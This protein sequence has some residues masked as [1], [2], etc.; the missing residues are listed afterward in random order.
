M[1]RNNNKRRKAINNNLKENRKINDSIKK[2]I[3]LKIEDILGTDPSKERIAN[4]Y[5]KLEN[6]FNSFET[7]KG[8]RFYNEIMKEISKNAKSEN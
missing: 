3:R 6:L 7:N 5:N 4:A 8:K 1:S 2:D